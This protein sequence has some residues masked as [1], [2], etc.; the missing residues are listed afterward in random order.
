MA[1]PA[2]AASRKRRLLT[3]RQTLDRP[4]MRLSRRIPHSGGRLSKAK[5][6][7]AT[8]RRGAASAARTAA[9]TRPGA[10][11]GIQCP[12]SGTISVSTPGNASE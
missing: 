12:P 9:A 7:H 4:T 10:L 6:I 11:R 2:G 3:G 8:S 1:A 5:L